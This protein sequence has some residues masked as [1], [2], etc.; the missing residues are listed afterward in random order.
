ME[1]KDWPK[2]SGSHQMGQGHDPSGYCPRDI[3]SLRMSPGTMSAAETTEYS[4]GCPK[5]R[6]F[7]VAGAANGSR[8]PVCKGL[9]RLQFT[10]G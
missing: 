8:Q 6:W 4:K 1:G 7:Q 3:E 2:S 9:L 5:S 10:R